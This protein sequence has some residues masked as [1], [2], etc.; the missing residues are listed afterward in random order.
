MNERRTYCLLF[1][2][3]IPVAINPD[4]SPDGIGIEVDF[5]GHPLEQRRAACQTK[6]L[7]EEGIE[8]THPSLDTGF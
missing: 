6:D 2:V 3:I 7:P 4:F 1:K 8:P 5:F